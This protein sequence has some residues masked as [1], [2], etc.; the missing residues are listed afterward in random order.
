[1]IIIN[2][3][4]LH[5]GHRERLRKRFLESGT[6]NFQEHEILELILFYALPRVNTNEISHRLI[7]KF[8][9]LSAVLDADLDELS[10]VDGLSKSSA[11]FICLM[12]DLCQKYTS[13]C[14]T[15]VKFCS[16]SD[17]EKYFIGYYDNITSEVCLILNINAKF[18]L[19]SNHCFP[20]NGL[21]DGTI[22]TRSLAETALSNCMRRIIIGQNKINALPVPTENDYKITTI[23]SDILTPLGIEVYDC[24]IYGCGKTFSMRK[25][26][27]FSFLE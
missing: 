27:A 20:I 24:I 22:S 19:I 11:A 4:N 16:A 15:A 14:H 13:A 23:F 8:G 9:C 2:A 3:N 17:I 10:T 25:N 6:S 1:M 26:G 5:N 18:E 7:D 12:H 21:L